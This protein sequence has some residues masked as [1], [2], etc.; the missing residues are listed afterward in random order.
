MKHKL[1]PVA[2]PVFAGNEKKYVNECLDSLWIASGEF[3]PRFEESF[4][5]FCGVPHALA[6]NSGTSA[7]HLALMALGVGPG[8]E[9]IVPT[10]TYIS[11][12]N[13]VRYCGAKPVLADSGARTMTLDPGSLESR[14]TPRTKGIVVV[15]LYG[16]PADMDA[17]ADVA[18]R[19]GLFV[20]E[21]CAEAH[22][23]LY[24][25]R[26]VGGLGDAGTFS[27]FGNKIISTGEGGMVT[28]RSAA[29]Y[30]KMRL[31]G[32]QGMDPAR[33]YWFTVV[34]YNYRMTNIEAA[35]GLAQL[36]Q[37]DKHLAGRRAVVELYRRHLPQNLVELPAEEAWARHAFW[38][39]TVRVKP[40]ARIGRDELM[41][42][43]DRDGIETRPVFYPMHL[44]PVYEEPC[45]TYPVAEDIAR[46][47][48]SLPTHG[49]LTEEDVVYISRCIQRACTRS[50]AAVTP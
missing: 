16:H 17:I 37:I 1:I 28:T 48:L 49:M 9:I 15:H 27:F 32:G 39:F 14:I 29:L 22:G 30:R 40:E 10:L 20:V 5:R 12:A 25:G 13:A 47:G 23:A 3:I 19:H 21:D 34:G 42:A 33:R 18:A 11:T 7:L 8:D 41:A 6:C 36:E 46:R 43:L 24:R 45:G 2:H 31:L 44:M 50:D 26:A 35:L 38:M 4:A